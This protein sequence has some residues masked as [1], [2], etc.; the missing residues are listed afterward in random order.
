MKAGSSSSPS[1]RSTA[2]K[3]GASGSKAPAGWKQWRAPRSH[4]PRKIVTDEQKTNAMIDAQRIWTEV[5]AGAEPWRDAIPENDGVFRIGLGRIGYNV[6]DMYPKHRVWVS[7]GPECIRQPNAAA[8]LFGV[9]SG[10]VSV[11]CMRC[12]KWADWLETQKNHPPTCPCTLLMFK[13]FEFTE[14]SFKGE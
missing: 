10:R 4:C 12:G 7:G 2:S 1:P 13:Q 9:N 6:E 8:H 14:F 3:N 5:D 11:G